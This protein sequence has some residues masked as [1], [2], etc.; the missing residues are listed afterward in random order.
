MRGPDENE[1][2]RPMTT[3]GLAGEMVERNNIIEECAKVAETF[4]GMFDIPSPEDGPFTQQDKT[5]A[6]CMANIASAIRAL[7]F[8][9]AAL[10]ETP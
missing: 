4:G 2:R 1:G 8:P 7:K 6:Q 3:Q 9:D 10:G 5:V